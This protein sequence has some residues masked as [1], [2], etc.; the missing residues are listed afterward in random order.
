[1]ADGRQRLNRLLLRYGQLAA[2]GLGR[3]YQARA[4]VRAR[5]YTPAAF[6][7]D[8]MELWLD[9]VDWIYVPFE[10]DQARIEMSIHQGDTQAVGQAQLGNPGPGSFRRTA[11]RPI[12]T[13]DTPI[14]ASTTGITWLPNTELL[15]VD[16]TGIPT[17]QSL[18]FYDGDL[19]FTPASTGVEIA[20][21]TIRLAVL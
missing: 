8:T 12:Y 20:I 21:A 18:D 17:G 10:S 4:E 7:S 13:N 1:M 5:T 11:L 6:L 19:L 16:V 14:P 15:V 9:A 3:L 2:D